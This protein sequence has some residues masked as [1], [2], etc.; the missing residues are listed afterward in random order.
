MSPDVITGITA[1]V[2]AVV[3]YIIRYFLAQNG[4][5]PTPITPSP[6]P[7]PSPVPTPSPDPFDKLPGLPGHPLMNLVWSVVSR[8]L[9]GGFLSVQ[10]AGP[11]DPFMDDA[12]LA[13]LASAIKADP[14]RL[15]K[16]K[17]LLN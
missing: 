15:T 11:S 5:T 17:T 12:A 10:D 2:A 14:D 9:G 8:W 4:T 3:G 7:T 13:A 1:I 16:M 6:T